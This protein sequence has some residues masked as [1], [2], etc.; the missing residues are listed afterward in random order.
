MRGSTNSANIIVCI[1]GIRDIT[2]YPGPE[3]RKQV[4][5]DII[6]GDTALEMPLKSKAEQHTKTGRSHVFF[7]LF[8]KVKTFIRRDPSLTIAMAVLGK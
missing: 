3:V 8:N 1:S 6:K 4:Q 5:V 2:I 7:Y